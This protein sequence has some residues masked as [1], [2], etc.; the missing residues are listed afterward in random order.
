MIVLKLTLDHIYEFDDFQINFTYPKKIVNSI[1]EN[2]HLDGRERFRYKKAV[3]LMGA[4][5]TGKTSLGKTLLR[6][7]GYMVNANP[8]PLCE[9]VS[10]EKGSFSIDFVNGDYRLQRLSAEITPSRNDVSI[11]YMD[12]EIGLLDSY[13]K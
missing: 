11:Q 7:F 4:N 2:E 13:E 6:I 1:I 12:S 3:I 8:L 10:G 9:M 5:A